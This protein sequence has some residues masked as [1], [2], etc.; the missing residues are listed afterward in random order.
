[1]AEEEVE[2]VNTSGTEK[3]E[4]MSTRERRGRRT[5][6]LARCHE[7]NADVST[8]EGDSGGEGGE[9]ERGGRPRRRWP[10][11]GDAEKVWRR[12]RSRSAWEVQARRRRERAAVDEQEVGGQ[13]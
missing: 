1:M 10:E 3:A 6:A 8:K 13:E 11:A 4:T 9:D 5:T 12:W 7:Q 2:E